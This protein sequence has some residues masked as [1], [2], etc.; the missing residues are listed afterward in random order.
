VSGL[1]FALFD[2]RATWDSAGRAAPESP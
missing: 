2:G 1:G